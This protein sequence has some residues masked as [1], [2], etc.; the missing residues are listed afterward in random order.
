MNSV[1]GLLKIILK[2]TNMGTF[3]WAVQ[4]KTISLMLVHAPVEL[5]AVK[6]NY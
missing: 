2:G 3:P 1:M 6:L 4:Y 5:L